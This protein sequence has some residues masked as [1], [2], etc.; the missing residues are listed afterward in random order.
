[1]EQLA[2]DYSADQED[3]SPSQEDALRIAMQKQWE[4][5]QKIIRQRGIIPDWFGEPSPLSRDKARLLSLL[6]DI[7]Y[8]TWSKHYCSNNREVTKQIGLNNTG[9]A[10]AVIDAC[11]KEG[12]I[13]SRI[14][15][16]EVVFEMTME[17]EHSLEEWQLEVELGI[18]SI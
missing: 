14:Y 16:G 12:L 2:F 4:D 13:S 6:Y 1:M 9:N 17:G 18:L 15:R 11:L 5:D 8:I 3:Y 7:G 10:K